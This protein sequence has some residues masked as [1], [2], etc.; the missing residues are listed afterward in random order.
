MLTLMMLF[1][2]M[3]APNSMDASTTLVASRNPLRARIDLILNRFDPA[4]GRVTVL[5]YH[6]FQDVESVDESRDNY[7]FDRN[8]DHSGERVEENRSPSSDSAEED[9]VVLS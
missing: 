3:V 7:G 5:A 1:T 9:P 4:P 2:A 8:D 6:E